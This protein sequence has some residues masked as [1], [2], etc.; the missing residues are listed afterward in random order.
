MIIMMMMMM[1]M[2]WNLA[3]SIK[4][5]IKLEELNVDLSGDWVL[6]FLYCEETKSNVKDFEDHSV[7]LPVAAID[8]GADGL[9][10]W[11]RLEFERLQHTYC[12][13]LHFQ[14]L[15]NVL[16]WEHRSWIKTSFLRNFQLATV[17]HPHNL[18]SE[19]PSNVRRR[20]PFQPR[21]KKTAESA[22]PYSNFL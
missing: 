14:K 5:V 6:K 20:L 2:R 22:K 1:S 18:N 4:F 21:S 10:I 19:Y 13:Y 11:Q 7:Q 8:M 17:A 12:R 9:T 16:I 15:P 3:S